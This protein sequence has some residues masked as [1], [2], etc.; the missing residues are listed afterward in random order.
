[1]DQRVIT[2]PEGDSFLLAA[3]DKKSASAI[4][5][6]EPWACVEDAYVVKER[7]NLAAHGKMLIVT[8]DSNSPETLVSFFSEYGCPATV[9][10][11]SQ[12]SIDLG[13][14][15][16]IEKAA[17][18]SALPDGEF[19]DVVYFGSNAVKNSAQM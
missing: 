8:E 5:L 18:V 15:S 11:I 17:D 13:I 4:A 3:S 12:Q 1:M 9:T 16:S 10:L 7:T 2:S 19:D 6:V 14:D